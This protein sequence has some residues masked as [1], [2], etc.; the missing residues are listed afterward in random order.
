MPAN[1][2]SASREPVTVKPIMPIWGSDCMERITAALEHIGGYSRVEPERE[3][4]HDREF[5]YRLSFLKAFDVLHGRGARDGFSESEKRH[6]LKRFASESPVID[7]M[8][9]LLSPAVYQ[10]GGAK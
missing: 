9:Q 5:Y 1:A 4:D 2:F 6:Q 10:E 7:A 8:R 3:E